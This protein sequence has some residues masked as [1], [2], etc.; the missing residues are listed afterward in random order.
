M[1]AVYNTSPFAGRLGLYKVVMRT[2]S[3]EPLV[4][5]G[6]SN[7]DL[8]NGR[9]SLHF[10]LQTELLRIQRS[11]LSCKTNGAEGKGVAGQ[12]VPGSQHP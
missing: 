8:A 11:V 6:T 4:S 3:K 2:H 10:R 7:G 1:C 12:K 9:A 5:L